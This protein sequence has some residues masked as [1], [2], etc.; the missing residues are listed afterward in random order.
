MPDR[1]IQELLASFVKLAAIATISDVMPLIGENRAIVHLGLRGLADIRAPG[2]RLLFESAGAGNGHSITAREI[3]F[4]VAPRINAAGRLQHA[5]LVMDLLAARDAGRARALAESLEKINYRRKQEQARLLEEINDISEPHANRRVLVFCGRGWHRGVL[6]IVAARLVE[7]FRRPVL[8]LSEENGF[9][10]GSGRSVPGINLSSLL[11][12][13]RHHLETFGG[14]EQAAG[15]TLRTDRIAAFREEICAACPEV[16][17]EEAIEIDANLRLLEI[18][19]VW[20]EITRLE[21]FGHG[22]PNPIFATRVQIESPQVFVTRSVSKV[23]VSQ[24]GGAFE[25]KQFG[26]DNGS[27]S[28]TPGARV[29][30]AYSLLPDR[31]RREGFTVVLEALRPAR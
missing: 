15:L 23:R 21:P 20:P 18:A 22:N 4:R 1:R 30:M 25:V 14:H 29:D 10:Y 16:C 26:C 19:D 6:G 5:S 8:V 17:A 9:A 24:N 31:W 27:V 11:E 28:V 12:R 2:L 13:V 3:A 7:Q